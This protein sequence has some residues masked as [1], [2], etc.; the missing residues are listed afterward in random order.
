MSYPRLSR[1]SPTLSSGSFIAFHL[2]F[3]SVVLFESILKG[4]RFSRQFVM[5]VP[6]LSFINQWV[7]KN[8]NWLPQ[9]FAVTFAGSFSFFFFFCIGYPVVSGS[10]VEETY[11][12]SIMLFLFPYQKLVVYLNRGLFLGYFWYQSICLFF[13]QYYTFLITF[14]Q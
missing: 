10:F 6:W 4:I 9:G 14:L 7:L 8:M 1:F 12:Y 11:P 3:W 13:C 2:T 5:I